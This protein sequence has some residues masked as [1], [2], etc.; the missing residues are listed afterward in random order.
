MACRRMTDAQVLRE[1][2]RQ[3][4]APLT[5]TEKRAILAQN[6]FSP[7]LVCGLGLFGRLRRKRRRRYR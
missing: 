5:T 2:R 3:K 1:A 6:R 7:R 4:R